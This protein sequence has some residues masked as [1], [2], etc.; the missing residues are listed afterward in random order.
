MSEHERK[1]K[2]IIRRNSIRKKQREKIKKMSYKERQEHF[3]GR[4]W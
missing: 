2:S 1:I 4:G 3:F